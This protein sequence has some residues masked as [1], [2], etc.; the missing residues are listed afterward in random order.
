MG[1]RATATAR[2]NERDERS[3]EPEELSE[4]QDRLRSKPW[5]QD[6]PRPWYR[7]H[8]GHTGKSVQMDRY[9]GN[10]GSHVQDAF[11]RRLKVRGLY[12]L[13]ITPNG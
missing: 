3:D 6:C 7:E 13:G 4:T 8:G 11:G 2:N 10:D 5:Q 9:D 12:I 1:D